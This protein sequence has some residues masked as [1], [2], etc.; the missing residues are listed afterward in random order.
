MRIATTVV[1]M[2]AV[3]G[4]EDQ[5]LFAPT[6]MDVAD[7]MLEVAKVK[8]D[9]VVWDLGCGD[10]RI[11]ILASKKYGC[12]S[13]GVE[14]DEHIARLATRL[15]KLNGVEKL[16]TIYKGDAL[17]TDFYSTATVVTVY[18]MPDL[19]KKLVPRFE[20][21][22]KGSRVVAH[23]KLIPWRPPDQTVRMKSK[24]DEREHTIYVW[25]IR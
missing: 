17:T 10:G 12:Q 1:L 14:L 15:V 9:D 23:D 7:R 22:P 24:T 5:S 4:A 18:L 21:L 3:F 20:K 8:K 2:L 25:K 11:L 13:Y 16:V 19:S 6:P